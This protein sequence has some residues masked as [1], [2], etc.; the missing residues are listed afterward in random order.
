MSDVGFQ[1]IETCLWAITS[2][3]WGE[4]RRQASGLSILI[5]EPLKLCWQSLRMA[6][7]Y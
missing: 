3:F 2:K 7:L 4:G 6:F 5:L 1:V